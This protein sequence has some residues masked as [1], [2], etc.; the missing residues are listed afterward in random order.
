MVPVDKILALI[1]ETVI[2]CSKEGISQLPCYE[3]QHRARLFDSLWMKKDMDLE[4]QT[5][6]RKVIRLNYFHL[7]V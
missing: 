7:E 5:G 6:E 4:M 3:F 2:K 1:D